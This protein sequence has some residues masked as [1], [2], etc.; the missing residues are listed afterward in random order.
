MITRVT[1][2]SSQVSMVSMSRMPPPSCTGIV[3]ASMMRSTA[4]TLTGLPD[5]RAVEIDD[6]EILEALRLERPRLRRRIAV[7]HRRARHVALLEPHAG[8]VLEV[9][10]GEQDHARLNARDARTAAESAHHGFHF[11]KLAISRKPSRWLFSGWNW[12]PTM[13]SRPTIAVTGPP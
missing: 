11:R 12:V 6:V 1:P 9:D 3:M 13:V 8:A 2:L 10:G 4:A 5:K 7:K